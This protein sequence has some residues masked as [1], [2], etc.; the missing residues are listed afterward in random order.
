MVT[1]PGLPAAS[2]EGP[3]PLILRLIR[4]IGSAATR[5]RGDLAYSLSKRPSRKYDFRLSISDIAQRFSTPDEQWA[6]FHNFFW[7]LA[8]VWLRDHREFFRVDKRG[9]GEDA[10]H[11]MWYLLVS[12]VRPTSFLE[13]G[14]YRGQVLSLVKL[15]AHHESFEC[16]VLGISPFSPVGDSV[17]EYGNFDY[18]R[19]VREFCRRFGTPLAQHELLRALSADEAAVEAIRNRKWDIGYIDGSHEYEIAR[20]DFDLVSSSLSQ[21]GLLVLDDAGLYSGYRPK[22]FSFAGHAGP[23]RILEQETKRGAQ[24]VVQAGHN[25]VLRPKSKAVM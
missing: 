13:I 15:I 5:I 12:E 14:V 2:H 24:I 8:P 17:S 1:A 23:S 22:S 25:V 20:R 9:F 10:I 21:S 18:E 6:Y 3:F 19:D 7:H 4:R 11:A 16:S